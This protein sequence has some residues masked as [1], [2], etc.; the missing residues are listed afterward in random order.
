LVKYINKSINL[1][2]TGFNLY[3]RGFLIYLFIVIILNVAGCVK[4]YNITPS[5]D[6]ISNIDFFIIKD[7]E[8]YNIDNRDF[9]LFPTLK[10]SLFSEDSLRFSFYPIMLIFFDDSIGVSSI[11][12][13]LKDTLNYLE[14]V[15]DTINI[16]NR[17]IDLIYIKIFFISSNQNRDMIYY[18]DIDSIFY[19]LV[20]IDNSQKNYSLK[21][22]PNLKNYKEVKFYY[23]GNSEHIFSVIDNNINL[24]GDLISSDF[25]KYYTK[26][27][28]NSIGDTIEKINYYKD[29]LIQHLI[30]QDSNFI[31]SY[32]YIKNNKL[33]VK[34]EDFNIN[35]S[36]KGDSIY[37][38]IGFF[39]RFLNRDSVSI[40][41]TGYFKENCLWLDS[42]IGEDNDGDSIILVKDSLNLLF[43]LYNNKKNLRE[44]YIFKN[45]C[46]ENWDLLEYSRK[47]ID[48]KS[49][50]IEE[51]KITTDSL[52]VYYM[53]NAVNIYHLFFQDSLNY[54]EYF[55]QNDIMNNERGTIHLMKNGENINYI[56]TI[57]GDSL[58]IN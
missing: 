25:F 24:K 15:V 23:Y 35:G 10:T 9:S 7:I 19:N 13:V 41:G 56:F 33:E 54:I 16:K 57:I 34:G 28:L 30:A 26:V 53:D 36:I 52:A 4:D 31:L 42:L 45:E 3:K 39:N 2:Y 32:Y 40:S 51:L 29:S 6:I 50:V 8:E 37:N 48:Q 11:G 22:Y 55:I 43:Y 27:I 46:M 1:S 20:Y 12:K 58:L 17:A 38:F 49:I 44:K 21:F 47:Q 18:N 14:I 5:E